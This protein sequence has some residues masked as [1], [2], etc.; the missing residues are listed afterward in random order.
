M[1]SDVARRPGKM[2]PDLI[3][4]ECGVP[5]HLVFSTQPHGGAVGTC[6]LERLVNS[7]L[8]DE[9]WGCGAVNAL[10]SGSVW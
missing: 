8:K 10:A 3:G 5:G 2:Q 1:L 4:P 9:A 7:I 6:S